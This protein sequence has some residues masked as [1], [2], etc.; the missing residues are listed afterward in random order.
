MNLPHIPLEQA[1]TFDAAA[2]NRVISASVRDPQ[3]QEPVHEQVSEMVA[4][5]IG[6][7]RSRAMVPIRTIT[8]TEGEYQHPPEDLSPRQLPNGYPVLII[9][10][11]DARIGM[12]GVKRRPDLK[13]DIVVA[14]L[15]A[16]KLMLE[17]V[18]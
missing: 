7:W 6:A 1:L 15:T 16:S 13:Y 4:E 5:C 8:V 17:G 18:Q 3:H 10:F 2:I 11:N 12:V 9:S 14:E